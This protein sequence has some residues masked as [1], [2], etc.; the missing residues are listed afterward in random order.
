MMLSEE[1]A[2]LLGITISDTERLHGGDLSEV[3]RIRCADGRT[4][5]AKSGPNATI[6][7]AMLR[8]ISAAGV[9]APSVLAVSDTVLVLEDLGE[10]DGPH[11]AW[12][13]LGAVLARLHQTVG[14]D[15]G[16]P[17]DYA[18][19]TVEIPNGA[20]AD[21][22]T[23]WAERRLLPTCAACPADLARRIEALCAR[24]SDRLP[25]RPAAAL[26]HGDLWTGNIMAQGA[27]VTG[28]IDPACYFGHAEVDLAMLR[29]FG[30]PGKEFW[31]H[32]GPLEPGFEERQPIY[33][34]WPALVHL[35]LFGAGYRGL[36]ERCL[37][38]AG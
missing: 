12:S 1:A 3:V 2:R 17:D 15:Y 14:P 9:P 10:D 13:D 4:A 32:Y 27:R 29:L 23:F 37:D 30:R 28:L 21:W 5:I 26:L 24:L 6:E 33:Q 35:R 25:E 36:V 22:P 31:D 20:A 38:Q 19:G 18:F 7:A 16:W 11:M 34:L 8:A